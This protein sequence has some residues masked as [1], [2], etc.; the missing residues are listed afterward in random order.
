MFADNYRMQSNIKNINENQVKTFV[1]LGPK[2]LQK[3]LS[4]AQ[5]IIGSQ[6]EIK[7]FR[8]GKAPEDLVKK[9]A[10]QER[11]KELVLEIAL[12]QSL[13]EV[14]E[15]NSLEVLETSQ[16]SIDKNEAEQLDYSVIL[17]LFPKVELVDLNKIKVQKKTVNVEEKEIEEALEAVKNSRANFIAKDDKRPVE[18]G[19]RVEVDFEV[20]KDGQIIEGGVSKSH[21]LIVGGKSF[22]PGFEDQLIGMNKGEKKLFSLTAPEDYFYKTV[23]GRSLDFNVTVVDIKKVITSELNDDFARSLGRFSGLDDLRNNIKDGLIKEKS[24]K[25]DQ[26]LR[27]EILDSIIQ[28]SKIDVPT[29][30]VNNQLDNMIADFDTS[31]HEKGLELGLYL[32]R[33]GKTQEELKKE[34]TKDAE[35]QV[36]SSL[37]LRRLAR[38]LKIEASQDEVD[39]AAEQLIQTAITRDGVSQNDI[40]VAKVKESLVVRIVNEK[41]LDYLESHCAV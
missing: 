31:L 32:N 34:W 5:E 8:R 27:L 9:Y 38:N 41:T 20:K 37:V 22:I 40:D 3:Y 29:K 16:L 1:T 7:G 33:I 6:A 14:I 39:E 23:A 25:E 30:L 24:V 15:A 4:K 13:A 17:D 12:E 19:D 11:I 10:G 18:I 26:K 21:P 28:Q 2:D 35:K 36:K